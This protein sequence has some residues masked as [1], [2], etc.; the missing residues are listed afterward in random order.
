MLFSTGCSHEPV[1]ND[2]FSTSVVVPAG[3]IRLSGHCAYRPVLNWAFSTGSKC[4][5]YWRAGT[6]VP[7]S[8]SEWWDEFFEPNFSM[9]K[10][11]LSNKNENARVAESKNFRELITPWVDSVHYPYPTRQIRNSSSKTGWSC[12]WIS[13]IWLEILKF[14]SHGIIKCTHAWRMK[15]R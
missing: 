4:A 14:L 1:L 3:T 5:R 8:G 15:C 12:V 11:Y 13:R 10:Q 2:Y 7:F 9:I 6:N